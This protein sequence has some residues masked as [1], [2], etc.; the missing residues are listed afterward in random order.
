MVAVFPIT[1]IAGRRALAQK[2]QDGWWKLTSQWKRKHDSQRQRGFPLCSWK[3]KTISLAIKDTIKVKQCFYWRLKGWILN[4]YYEANIHTLYQLFFTQFCN[5]R[6]LF[7]IDPKL[8]RDLKRESSWWNMCQVPEPNTPQLAPAVLFYL[9]N[10]S[11]WKFIILSWLGISWRNSGEWDIVP[12]HC[13]FIVLE[14]R[15]TNVLRQQ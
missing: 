10:K 1:C 15:Q 6:I 2:L 11:L 7:F 14:E 13:E 4:P 9:F 8:C 5:K 12:T 3:R